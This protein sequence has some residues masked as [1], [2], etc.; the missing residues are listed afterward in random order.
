MDKVTVSNKL[1]QVVRVALVNE[2][3]SVDELKLDPRADSAPVDRARLSKHALQLVAAG[4]LKLR[5]A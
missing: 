1:P 4:H 5:N 2:D 3:G